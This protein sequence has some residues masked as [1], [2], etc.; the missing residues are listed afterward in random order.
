M[1]L[2]VEDSDAKKFNFNLIQLLEQLGKFYPDDRDI[3]I[4]RDKIVILS[5]ANAKFKESFFIEFNYHDRV[6]DPKY[7]KLI[8]KIIS[9]WKE[10]KDEK[11][12]K[13]V[14]QYLQVLLAHSIKCMKRSDLL[15]IINKFRKTPL[16]M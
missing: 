6:S 15:D 8:E 10:S 11:M 2:T 14:S 1:S 12:K 9:L 5:K 13:M 16:T 7:L 4:Y 3:Q